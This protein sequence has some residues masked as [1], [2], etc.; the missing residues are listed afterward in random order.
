[1]ITVRLNR[2]LSKL[3][4]ETDTSPLSVEYL[5]QETGY[6]RNSISKILKSPTENTTTGLIN[7]LLQVM[8]KHFRKIDTYKDL[9]DDG[10][11]DMLVKE[12]ITVTPKTR[13]QR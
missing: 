9:S 4:Y 12:F 6:H 7:A 10:L 3:S 5:A 8:L 1:M 11:M 2:L 13:K